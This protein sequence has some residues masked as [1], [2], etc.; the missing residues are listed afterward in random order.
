MTKAASIEE[1]IVTTAGELFRREFENTLRQQ[2]LDVATAEIEFVVKAVADRVLTQTCMYY[3][4]EMMGQV[5][6]QRIIIN[7][8]PQ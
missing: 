6:E 4:Q 2:L 3:R 5:L 8:V 1:A 7:G